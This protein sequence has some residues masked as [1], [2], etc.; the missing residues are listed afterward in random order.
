MGRNG[1]K[2]EVLTRKSEN[3][4]HR[5]K[6]KET[7]L[8]EVSK[9]LEL[10]KSN[11]SAA[12]TINPD[13]VLKYA[14]DPDIYDFLFGFTY[15][16]N[17]GKPVKADT[18]RM[19]RSFQNLYKNIMMACGYTYPNYNKTNNEFYPKASPVRDIPESEYP[20]FC[21]LLQKITALIYTF[22]S[23]RKADK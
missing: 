13:R 19:N 23:E 5:L 17:T 18:E 7:T 14:I 8:N 20:D 16:K 22:K 3:L 15:E 10:L 11:K 12:N 4:E 21:E 2:I 1:K 6:V 9:E